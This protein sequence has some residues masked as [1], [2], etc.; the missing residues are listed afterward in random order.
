MN[1]PRPN[2]KKY[3]DNNVSSQ[4]DKVASASTVW[5]KM[6]AEDQLQQLRA[7][8]DKLRE[9]REGDSSHDEALIQECS[10]VEKALDHLIDNLPNL[11]M[12]DRDDLTYSLRDGP[13]QESADKIATLK[14]ILGAVDIVLNS[15]DELMNFV[16]IPRK[17][18]GFINWLRQIIHKIL[19]DV[20]PS[21]NLPTRSYQ[22]LKRLREN[23]FG[24]DQDELSKRA[25][26]FD[27]GVIASNHFKTKEREIDQAKE[28]NKFQKL[29]LGPEY[30]DVNAF[31]NAKEQSYREA[32]SNTTPIEETH[33]QE[34]RSQKEHDISEGLSEQIALLTPENVFA[35]IDRLRNLDP[36]E[37]NSYYQETLVSLTEKAIKNSLEGFK[38]SLL[39]GLETQQYN[40]LLSKFKNEFNQ[41]SLSTK[42]DSDQA[43]LRYF[44]ESIG[45]P[46]PD[47]QADKMQ[48]NFFNLLIQLSET[49]RARLFNN[50]SLFDVG[51]EEENFKTKRVNKPGQ[52]ETVAKSF[53]QI[54][55]LAIAMRRWLVGKADFFESIKKNTPKRANLSDGTVDNFLVL[56]IKREQLKE[57]VQGG[58][59]L[60]V[61][62]RVGKSVARTICD[63]LNAL[64]SQ[65]G[66][67]LDQ[68]SVD[69]RLE[70]HQRFITMNDNQKRILYSE[71]L[72][73]ARS[74]LSQ[75]PQACFSLDDFLS[76]L[77]AY[78]QLYNTSLSEVIPFLEASLGI[79]KESFL[80]NLRLL[81]Y[82]KSIE[83]NN[84]SKEEALVLEAVR[85]RALWNQNLL[86]QHL[87]NSRLGFVWPT[88]VSP[89]TEIDAIIRTLINAT[90]L[91]LND[92]M[93][94]VLMLREMIDPK[95][96]PSL[97][98]DCLEGFLSDDFRMTDQSVSD[99]EEKNRRL[100]EAFKT[101]FSNTSIPNEIGNK[102]RDL[103]LKYKAYRALSD[104]PYLTSVFDQAGINASEYTRRLKHSQESE[105]SRF[106]DEIFLPCISQ[107]NLSAI[108]GL[109]LALSSGEDCPVVEIEESLNR[110][111]REKGK[112]NAS[113]YI[114]VSKLMVFWERL[115]PSFVLG[116]KRAQ[117]FS[118][119]LRSLFSEMRE[120]LFSSELPFEMRL[121]NLITLDTAASH[122]EEDSRSFYSSLSS[123]GVNCS[124]CPRE[125]MIDVLTAMQACD[126]AILSNSRLENIIRETK[127]A[128]T[129]EC[130]RLKELILS[131]LGFEEIIHYLQSLYEALGPDRY[132]QLS[133]RTNLLDFLYLW[134]DR[135]WDPDTLDSMANDLTTAINHT[136]NM[137][138][139]LSQKWGLFNE[140]R[141]SQVAPVVL[142]EPIKRMLDEYSQKNTQD[143]KECE[144]AILL[145]IK[146][147]SEEEFQLFCNTYKQKGLSSWLKRVIDSHGDKAPRAQALLSLYVEKLLI[148]CSSGLTEYECIVAPNSNL[149]S[150]AST[151]LDRYL[152]DIK[153]CFSYVVKLGKS[154]PREQFQNFWVRFE[155]QLVAPLLALLAKRDPATYRGFFESA[156]LDAAT[157][158]KARQ[159]ADLVT[160]SAQFAIGKM[161]A[162]LNKKTNFSDCL[163]KKE[164][165]KL[166]AIKLR[167][168]PINSR[169]DTYL[170]VFRSH[171]YQSE[172]RRSKIYTE[173][174]EGILSHIV[175]SYGSK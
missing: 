121:E 114:V 20:L 44:L 172:Y 158:E 28:K 104:H 59:V 74:L 165:L 144:E 119:R 127:D 99:S 18:V 49:G 57:P 151:H 30:P 148:D 93:N 61:D 120:S 52:N 91:P 168:S 138:Y 150:Y 152:E 88:A 42:F 118:D 55:D 9:R 22:S 64:I 34:L 80:G 2:D 37:Y 115:N 106:L 100:I 68:K 90:E 11:E 159:F 79:T 140:E 13:S 5:M 105:K 89:G 149:E 169:M 56:L 175:A 1:M 4:Q 71:G 153:R 45:L 109:V 161:T 124:Q 33:D 174:E 7:L 134:I 129:I 69:L 12:D 136:E 103:E 10:A 146:A 82:F 70:D 170:S 48:E 15:S 19:G 78:I 38:Q 137:G 130:D 167:R 23:S 85:D 166:A 128:L 67:K 141:S 31:L 110:F 81:A 41:Y 75:L 143:T 154:L 131:P 76:K 155:E 162:L 101:V 73:D 17:L 96:L 133:T 8:R 102:S 156:L 95:A 50:E 25:K 35:A 65:F 123:R 6:A 43:A 58:T 24:N 54:L 139:I 40:S 83:K 53:V 160:H 26:R 36:E 86:N 72:F 29:V 173:A 98:D 60:Q 63:G 92:R 16:N 62:Q 135:V 111:Y 147:M 163:K 113:D 132:N 87:V 32:L 108:L 84:D 46:I 47:C 112:Y 39:T 77:R 3:R 126:Q 157:A 27:D 116:G 122:T 97:V 117:L 66:K 51:D 164:A 94:N 14:I 145:K 107:A 171:E 125:R 21:N 142:A